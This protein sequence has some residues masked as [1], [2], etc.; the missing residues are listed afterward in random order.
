MPHSPSGK[1]EAL[2]STGPGRCVS[3]GSQEAQS[4]GGRQDLSGVRLCSFN[5]SSP[6]RAP[7]LR[8]ASLPLGKWRTALGE[9][10]G[11]PRR[12]LRGPGL[13]LSSQASAHHLFCPVLH[14]GSADMALAAGDTGPCPV[15]A[16]GLVSA[17][18]AVNPPPPSLSFLEMGSGS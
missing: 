15:D 2:C 13:G 11:E 4:P 8:W 6:P 9:G 3:R 5:W 14:Q 16:M 7:S 18:P 12:G 1:T 17:R 10:L